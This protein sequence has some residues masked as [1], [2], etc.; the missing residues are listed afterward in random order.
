[1][2]LSWAKNSIIL[3]FPSLPFLLGSLAVFH[4]AEDEFFAIGAEGEDLFCCGAFFG[5]SDG[6]ERPLEGDELA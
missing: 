4:R 1:M 5:E 6:L 3:A 2:V